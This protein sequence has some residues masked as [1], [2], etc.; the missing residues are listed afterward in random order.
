MKN[1]ILTLIE[2]KT[3]S[4]SVERELARLRG[5]ITGCRTGVMEKVYDE[6]PN[7]IVIDE[8]FQEGR[9]LKVATALKEDMVLRHIPILMLV[10]DTV[11]E[12]SRESRRIE[13]FVQKDKLAK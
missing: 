5:T 2:D 4:A 12:L 6:L 7:L 3:L 13:G 8:E 11:L 10:E 1:K 9:G